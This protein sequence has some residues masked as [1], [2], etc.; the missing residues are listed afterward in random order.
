MKKETK[1]II[2]ILYDYLKEIVDQVD[3]DMI[4]EK[5]GYAYMKGVE[6]GM[7]TVLLLIKETINKD[8]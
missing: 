2:E 7:E 3:L 6:C 1:E 5:M 4:T 8:E